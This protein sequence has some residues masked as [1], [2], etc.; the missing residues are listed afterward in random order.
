MTAG[1]AGLVLID[2][3]PGD[4]RIPVFDDGLL[5]GDGCFEAIRSYGGRPFALEQHLT[6][7]AA[8]AAA[9]RIPLPPVTR[10]AGWVEV[11][12]AAG[13]DCVVRI[14]LTRGTTVPG[15]Q[16]PPRCIVI[17]HPIP[18]PAAEL[19]LLPV[20]APWHPAGRAWELSGVKTISYAPNQAATRL[21]REAG[22]DDAL[23]L[24]DSGTILEGPTFSFAWVVD[25]V[26]ETA[27]VDLGILDSITRRW[28][29][30]E[31]P[32]IGIKVIE[33][34]FDIGRLTSA[35]EAMAISTVKQVASV[36]AVGDWSYPI[37]EVAATLN[38]ALSQ[39]AQ[40]TAPQITT[41]R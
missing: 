37:G 39:R 26:L 13:G 33:G 10:I 9:L 4:G 34:R 16:R 8:S 25:G 29:I 18:A 35:T 1:G 5:R 36:R 24:S 23:L 19:T 14:V 12:A 40:A 17:S 27:G 28:V 2:G 41:G 21:A 30:A 15:H 3:E 20:A 11:V 22:F 32:A 38:D 6:R 31:S 7:L